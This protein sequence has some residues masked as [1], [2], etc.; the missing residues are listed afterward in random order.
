MPSL[1]DNDAVRWTVASVLLFAP[2]GV[3]LSLATPP[4][5]SALAT[6]LLGVNAIFAWT[7]GYWLVYRGGLERLGVAGE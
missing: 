7:V 5:A 6:L 4:D 1:L 3:V 2:A